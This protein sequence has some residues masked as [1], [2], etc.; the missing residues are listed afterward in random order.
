M[1]HE[2]LSMRK[3]REVLRLRWEQGLSHRQ[4]VASCRLG[5]GTVGEYL[6]RAAAAG[7]TWPLPEGLTDAELERQLFPPPEAISAAERPLPEWAEVHRELRKKGVTLLLLWEEYRAE[8]PKAF[9]YSRFCE[10]YQ[11]W[12]GAA[13]P[14]MHQVHQAGEKLFVDY[15][16]QTLSIVDR[17]TG[18]RRDVQVFVATLGASSYTFADVS[19]SQALPDWIAS[20]V[21]AFEF[22]GGVPAVVVPDNL[23]AGV[24]AACYYDPDLNP[25]YQE[26]ARHY[27]TAI[28]PTRPRKPR[29][30][31]KVE[32]GVQQVERWVL[33]PL[34]NRT[35]FS[36]ADLGGAIRE[37]VQALN[38]RP[39]QGLP[40]SRRE[41][42]ETLEQPALRP[43]PAQPYELALWKRARVHLDY[44][45]QVDDHFYSVPYRLV[46]VEVEVRL[47]AATVEL[48]YQGERVASHARSHRKYGYT[49]LPEHMPAGHLAY[50]ERDAQRL[51][52]R[53]SQVGTQTLELCRQILASRPHPEQGYRACLGIL[54]LA[55][56]HGGARLER[57]A[58][59]AL[60]TAALSYRSVQAILTHHLEETPLPTAPIAATPAAP[61]LHANLRGAAY[62]RNEEDTR[63]C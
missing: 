34:R 29:D 39:G 10:R 14:R 40:A 63:P 20:H 38:D 24:T 42:F 6:R 2:R 13:E 9:R 23:K 16:G 57:A 25:T 4:I 35:F 62:Y 15:A 44:H 50:A 59:R 21:R 27:G 36:L 3:I 31:S 8:N 17:T 30:K 5:Q 28:L 37:Q 22:F 33:A 54:R 56:V 48:F 12:R 47:A 61:L 45:V 11:Q 60:A 51:L 1:P 18:E 46:R 43:L 58:V 53:A 26:L 55:Q 7:L 52:Q 32:N 41:L 19:W 49:T